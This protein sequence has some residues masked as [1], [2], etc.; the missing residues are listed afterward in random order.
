MFSLDCKFDL[1][2]VCKWREFVFKLLEEN[3]C[4]SYTISIINEIMYNCVN[5]GFIF[6]Y[7]KISWHCPHW[8]YRLFGL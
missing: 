8:D 5:I 7:E 1:S 6:F 2:Y 4:S 3:A